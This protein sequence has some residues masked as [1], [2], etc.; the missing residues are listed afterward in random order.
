MK[1]KSDADI[2]F[3]TA[4]KSKGREW[5]QVYIAEDFKNPDKS[6][7]LPEQER[8]LLYVAATRATD[9]LFVNDSIM[10]LLEASEKRSGKSSSGP[11]ADMANFFLEAEFEAEMYRDDWETQGWG[12]TGL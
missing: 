9:K 4:H 10:M 11:R 2:T 6:G 1:V 3:T 5:S 12:M 8:N 7:K